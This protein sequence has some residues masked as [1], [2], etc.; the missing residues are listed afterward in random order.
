MASRVVGG[1]CTLLLPVPEG[2]TVP[3]TYWAY[4]IKL[5]FEWDDEMKMAHAW[6]DAGGPFVDDTSLTSDCASL[7]ELE[8]NVADLKEKLDKAVTQARRKFA[9]HHGQR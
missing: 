4:E 9:K 8:H 7:T 6:I 1:A 5:H 3:T 2:L